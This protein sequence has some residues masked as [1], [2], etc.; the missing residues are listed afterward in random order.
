MRRYTN[1]TQLELIQALMDADLSE[2]YSVF[3][4][5]Y[6]I[7][8][9]PGLCYLAMHG[10]SCIGAVVSKLEHNKRGVLRGYIAML[11]VQRARRKSGLGTRLVRATIA[12]MAARRCEE[13]VLEAE[14][15]NAAALR[16]YHNLGFIRDKRLEK[17]YLNGND[18]F[19]LKLRLRSVPPPVFRLPVP[20]AARP[21]NTHGERAGSS[22]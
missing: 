16:L 6:F 22:T 17:Y 19:R 13:V 14:T 9:W 21:H 11:A 20:P 2:P 15:S 1:E 10:A 18:A 8:Q 7:H 12:A 3:T 5:R 4:Y